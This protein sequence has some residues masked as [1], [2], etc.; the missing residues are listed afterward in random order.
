MKT[1]RQVLKENKEQLE[2]VPKD[3]FY[4]AIYRLC[5]ADKKFGKAF[6]TAILCECSTGD[7]LNHLERMLKDPDTPEQLRG[8]LQLVINKINILEADS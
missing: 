6:S 4:R 8:D 3:D 1:F 5:F 2:K 7:R